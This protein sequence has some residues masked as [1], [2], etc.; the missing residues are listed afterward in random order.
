MI[1]GNWNG[2]S[3]FQQGGV[4]FISNTVATIGQ[5]DRNVTGNIRFTS[6]GWEGWQAN[7]SGTLAGTAPDTQF[8]GNIV[9]QAPSSTGTGV[10]SASFTMAGPSIGTSMRWETPVILMTNN[11]STQPINSCRG[12]LLTLVWI[13][14]R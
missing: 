1:A 3:D 6:A 14:F 5:N 12:Q 9:L 11:V 8:V 4:R 10:C 13:F 7:F 2:T